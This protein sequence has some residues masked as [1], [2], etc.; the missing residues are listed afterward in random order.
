[1]FTSSSGSRSAC[2]AHTPASLRYIDAATA[3]ALNGG[4]RGAPRAARDT[5]ARS[6]RSARPK[7]PS[8]AR[9]SL[10]R[11]RAYT[12][13]SAPPTRPSAVTIVHS[14]PRGPSP[15]PSSRIAASRART[16]SRRS[17]VCG[18]TMQRRARPRSAPAPARASRNER[19]T[20]NP[21]RTRSRLPDPPGPP[22][23]DPAQRAPRTAWI[24]ATKHVS[25]FSNSS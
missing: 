9:G 13:P 11:N 23:P 19:I 18:P 22:P 6:S 1:M 17:S 24:N 10:L 20:H 12:T 15:R 21:P 5:A 25:R 2:A 4:V 8:T 14:A 3:Q 16:R 7:D